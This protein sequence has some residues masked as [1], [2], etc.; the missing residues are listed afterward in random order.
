M[1]CKKI[2]YLR[3][4]TNNIETYEKLKKIH[5]LQFIIDKFY[6]KFSKTERANSSVKLW[7]QYFGLVTLMQQFVAAEKSGDGKLHLATVNKMLDIYYCTGIINTLNVFRCTCKISL[8]LENV[9]TMEEKVDIH[10]Q[11]V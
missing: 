6:N 9:V 2:E 1:L 11:E 3:F 5:Y 10:Y 8:D 7:V 4:V